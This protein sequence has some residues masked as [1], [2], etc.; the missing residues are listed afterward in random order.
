MSAGASISAIN[1]NMSPCSKFAIKNINWPNL[2]CLTPRGSAL[3]V[4]KTAPF[5]DQ[6]AN[7]YTRCKDLGLVDCLVS[8]TSYC[9]LH[10]CAPSIDQ[11]SLAIVHVETMPDGYPCQMDEPF[12]KICLTG[13][14]SKENRTNVCDRTRPC[15]SAFGTLSSSSQVCGDLTDSLC[16]VWSNPC[17]SPILYCNPNSAEP[18]ECPS[19]TVRAPGSPCGKCVDT[20]DAKTCDFT[21][22]CG[23]GPSFGL[24]VGNITAATVTAPQSPMKTRTCSATSTCVENEMYSICV[25]EGSSMTNNRP[26]HKTSSLR[27]K[28]KSKNKPPK[29]PLVSSVSIDS[30]D[31]EMVRT[32]T[33]SIYSLIVTPPIVQINQTDPCDGF[34]CSPAQVCIS[35]AGSPICTNQNVNSCYNLCGNANFDF[36]KW[37]CDCKE[38]CQSRSACCPDFSTLCVYD[39]GSGNQNGNNNEPV[40]N[41][42]RSTSYSVIAVIDADPFVETTA[43]STQKTYYRSDAKTVLILI[44]VISVLVMVIGVMGARLYKKRHL[45]PSQTSQLSMASPKESVIKQAATLDIDDVGGSVESVAPSTTATESTESLARR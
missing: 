42:S 30:E 22:V 21:S 11:D 8:D 31:F 5:Q 36:S 34:T 32:E 3:N 2:N 18:Q 44:G 33:E 23:S 17:L 25:P 10:C 12:P 6:I 1:N 14:C 28:T 19:F 40:G 26:P 35:I 9:K 45:K 7:P 39:G 16:G 29:T 38:D 13:K 24:C 20:A 41:R 27:Q 15:C 43:T 4:S 37:T